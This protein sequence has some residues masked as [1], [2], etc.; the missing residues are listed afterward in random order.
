MVFGDYYNQQNDEEKLRIQNLAMK[1]TGCS[2][3]TFYYRNRTGGW[4]LSD[5]KVLNLAFETNKVN[6]RFDV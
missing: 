3:A 2:I 1:E 5:K 6:F 4:S